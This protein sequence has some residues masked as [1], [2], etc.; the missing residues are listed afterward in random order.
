MIMESHLSD[1]VLGEGPGALDCRPGE[2]LPNA[3]Q[4]GVK[5]SRRRQIFFYRAGWCCLNGA[6]VELWAVMLDRTQR[7]L[8]DLFLGADPLPCFPGGL[9]RRMISVGITQVELPKK[10]K[11]YRPPNTLR[12]EFDQQLVMTVL[13]PCH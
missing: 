8:S 6:T 12:A 5:I 3:L 13:H 7:Y 1:A 2:I 11:P 10:R 9:K 4:V